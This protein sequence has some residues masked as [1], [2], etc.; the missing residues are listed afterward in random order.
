VLGRV[1]GV[2]VDETGFFG[3]MSFANWFHLLK[4][5]DGEWRIV[6]KA[7]TTREA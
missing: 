5:D 4:G 3:A 2:R 7:F 1:A 6:S